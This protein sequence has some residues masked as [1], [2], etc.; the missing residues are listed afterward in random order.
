MEAKLIAYTRP[1]W[2]RGEYQI[3][4]D[5]EDRDLPRDAKILFEILATGKVREVVETLEAAA[6]KTAEDKGIK[7]SF[8]HKREPRK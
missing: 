2:D 6:E 1:H 5:G 8:N 7:L 3:V 4:L